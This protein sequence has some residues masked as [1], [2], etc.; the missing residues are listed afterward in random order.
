MRLEPAMIELLLVQVAQCVL[1][2]DYSAAR[3][4]LCVVKLSEAALEICAET[5]HP[6]SEGS[7][8]ERRQDHWVCN[9]FIGGGRKGKTLI[10]TW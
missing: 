5:V 8:A 2:V 7:S 3:C 1:E 6:C 4:V 9:F 10:D